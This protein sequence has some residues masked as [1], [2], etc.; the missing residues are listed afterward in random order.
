[1]NADDV[2]DYCLRKKGVTESLPFDENTLVFKVMGK[3]FVLLSLNDV[4]KLSLKSLPDVA[5]DLRERYSC[6]IPG[7]HLNKKHWNTIILDN[8]INDN[9]IFKWIDISYN[10]VVDKLTIKKRNELKEL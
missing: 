9:L 1:M 4:P 8:Q 5:I 7:Y 6:V 2:R 3:I 10:L